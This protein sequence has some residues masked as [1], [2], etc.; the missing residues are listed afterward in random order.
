MNQILQDLKRIL[1]Q[2]TKVNFILYFLKANLLIKKYLCFSENPNYYAN[3]YKQYNLTGAH[4][5]KLGHGND[6]AAKE[7][8]AAWPGGLQIGGGIT[9]ENAE[10]WL[11]AGAEKVSNILLIVLIEI[12]I[13]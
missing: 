12:F 5:I 11:N 3:L 2:G 9:L 13:Y 7:C 8:L 6:E 1:C 4:V 10:E